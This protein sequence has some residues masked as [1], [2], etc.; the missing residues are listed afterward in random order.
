[1]ALN[2]AQYEQISSLFKTL[3]HIGHSTTIYYP[4]ISNNQNICIQLHLFFLFNVYK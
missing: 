2:A 3:E 4:S 1:M